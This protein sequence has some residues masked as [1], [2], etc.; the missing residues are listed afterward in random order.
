LAQPPVDERIIP[1]RSFDH[2]SHEK[3]ACSAV[4]TPC[5]H[6]AHKSSS[7]SPCH[8]WRSNVHN[9]TCRA[10]QKISFTFGGAFVFHTQLHLPGT[11]NR[12][13]KPGMFGML[14][15]NLWTTI[16]TQ[17]DPDAA[18][19]EWY[20]RPSPTRKCSHIEPE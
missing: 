15:R 16:A 13:R 18:A 9:R 1:W 10:S 20:P 17:S 19:E 14:N 12:R 4:S 5:K 7:W 2:Y 3:N 6:S 11:L 8:Q